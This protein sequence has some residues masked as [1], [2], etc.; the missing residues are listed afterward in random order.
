MATPQ[1]PLPPSLFGLDHL[2]WIHSKLFVADILALLPHP[3]IADVYLYNN[4]P[5]RKVEVTGI[6]VGKEE[7]ASFVLYTVDDG[8]GL[9]PCISWFPRTERFLVDR[10]TLLLGTLVRIAGRV[11]DYRG[12]RQ[13]TVNAITAESDPNI[14]TLRWLEVIDLKQCVYDVPL[15]ISGGHMDRARALLMSPEANRVAADNC[16]GDR[17]PSAE[18]EQLLREKRDLDTTEEDLKRALKLFIQSKELVLVPYTVLRHSDEILFLVNRLLM[19]QNQISYPSA[20]RVNSTIARTV[21]TL[22]R[23]GFMYLYN[24]ED[25]VYEIIRH[26]VNLGLAILNLIKSDAKCQ[27]GAV[28]ES[29]IFTLRVD[30]KFKYVHRNAIEKSVGLLVNASEIY[31]VD[32]KEYRAVE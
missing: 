14:E 3:E 31:E 2:F 24:E 6:I 27:G 21:Q 13:I 18:L 12:Q 20:Q 15:Q 25:D 16:P 22:V 17:N 23:E 9:V 7:S 8:T 10:K 5:L 30:K 32:H 26:D 1:V 11:S 28:L 29:I 4:H 19:T